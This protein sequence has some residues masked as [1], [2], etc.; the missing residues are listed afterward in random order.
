MTRWES[1][2]ETL[3]E[4]FVDL[5]AVVFCPLPLSSPIQQVLMARGIHELLKVSPRPTMPNPSTPYGR[6]TPKT[7]IWPFWRWPARRA[8]GLKPSST[9]LDTPYRM[10]LLPNKLISSL[11]P[12]PINQYFCLRRS[13]PINKLKIC[14]TFWL[15][16]L[17]LFVGHE[18]G[19]VFVFLSSFFFMTYRY[20][21]V[22]M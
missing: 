15:M 9:P 10:G 6:T 13:F 20:F 4:I 22:L 17:K 3:N 7:A 14:Q 21:Y 1:C 2:D 11:I 18:K 16:G 8:G 5:P 19:I 12:L